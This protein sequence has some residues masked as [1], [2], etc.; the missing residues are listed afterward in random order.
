[1]IDHKT[2]IAESRL[3]I[4][5]YI[6]PYGNNLF[7]PTKELEQMLNL[8]LVGFSLGGLPLRTRSKAVKTEICKILGYPVPK[9]FKKT[10]PRFIGQNFDVYTQQ[11]LNVQIW[12]EEIE[13]SR[14]Y[15]FIQ[16]DE[17]GVITRVKVI[18]GDQ[19][20][21]YDKTGTLTSKYQATM[22]PYP[23][24]TLFTKHES[25]SILDWCGNNISLSA[26]E[27][28]DIPTRGQLMRIGDIFNM[29]KPLEGTT[30]PY[31]N[32]LQE[33]NRG[34]ALHK[35]VCEK[36]GYSAI[37]DDGTYPDVYNQLLEIKL[38]TSPTIDLGIHSPNDSQIVYQADG[39]VFRSEDVRYVI[40]DGSVED[41]E[42]RIDRLHMVSGR[43][44]AEH[45]PLF[46]GLGRNVK[47]QIHLPKDFFSQD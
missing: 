39:S 21:T 19:L 14:R 2:N 4:S 26:A 45:F 38:Q 18:T 41:S 28:N 33:R 9:S 30:I 31:L 20:V 46:G 44:F 15:V 37:Y 29:L 40:V 8:H 5:E 34:A 3:T 42:I 43:D 17:N 32:A 27:S 16:A 25:Q 36:L 23:T 1:M 13:G 7:I 6:L 11:S 22:A 35:S 10:Q 12:N 24:G 47:L